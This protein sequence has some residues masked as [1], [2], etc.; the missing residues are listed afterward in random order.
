MIAIIA[1]AQLAMASGRVGD[2][3]YDTLLHVTLN[4]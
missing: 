2:A 1:H 3:V 4:S